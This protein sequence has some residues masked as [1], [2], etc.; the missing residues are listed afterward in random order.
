MRKKKKVGAIAINSFAL[1]V[2]LGAAFQAMAKDATTPYPKMAPTDQYLMTD[3]DAEIALARSPAPG[4]ISRDAALK[5]MGTRTF[6]FQKSESGADV[7]ERATIHTKPFLPLTE[8]S[9]DEV[10]EPVP[11]H[12]ARKLCLCDTAVSTTS[13]CSY[14]IGSRSDGRF[15]HV[16]NTRS[17]GLLP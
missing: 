8:V 13:R 2:V 14:V 10:Q 6:G 4:S 1:L 17:A 11:R 7:H 15:G 16:L 9:N 5:H 12:P 3:Q